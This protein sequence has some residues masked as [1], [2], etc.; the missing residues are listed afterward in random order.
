MGGGKNDGHMHRSSQLVSILCPFFLTGW[1]FAYLTGREVRKPPDY[2]SFLPPRAGITYR[3]PVFGSEI[4]RI[5]NA[6]LQPNAGDLGNLAFIINEYSTMSPF[7]G[8]N[9]RLLL[10]HQSYFALYDGSGNFIKDL[11]FEVNATSEPRW[12]RTDADV[13]YYVKGNQLKQYKTSTDSISLVRTFRE[14]SAIHGSGESDICFDG[15]HLVLVGDNK[16]IFVYEISSD[17]KGPVLN[18]EG[19][20]GF[21]Q[22]YITPNDNVL[23]GWYAVGKGRFQGIEL[24]DR[25]M[26]FLRQVAP[27]IGH[28]DVTRDIN[29][30]EVLIWAN[31]ADPAPICSNGVVKIN[32]S[33]GQQTCLLS[34]DWS[35]AFHVSAP[36]GNGWCVVTTYAPSDPDPISNWPLYTNEILQLKLDGSEVRRLAHHRSRP[37][38]GYNYTPRTSLSRDGSRL[39]YS[40]N[41]GLQSI[42]G[43]LTEYSDVYLMAVRLEENESGVAYNCV[44]Y[45]NDYP[46][47]SDGSAFLALEAGAYASFTFV[48][49]GV[50][51]LGYCDN[52]CG[53]AHVYVDGIYQASVDTFAHSPQIQFPLFSIRD[54]PPQAHRLVIQVAGTHSSQSGGAWVWID[55]FDVIFAD[56]GVSRFEQT[57]EAINYASCPW[58]RLESTLYSGGA[59]LLAMQPGALAAF[60]FRGT[61]ARWIGLRD[62]W[63]GTALVYVDGT[64]QA[65]IDTYSPVPETQ[66]EIYVVSGLHPGR[67]TLIIAVTGKKNPNSSNSWVWVDAFEPLP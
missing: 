45:R 24:Y 31:A 17:Q 9:S 44:W 32:L 12:S 38:N 53:I 50:T 46:G 2:F 36:D 5:T 54:L 40:S 10:M 39:V 65:E 59:A 63:S 33:D 13:F 57:S 34:L 11:P 37:F 61:G 4:K 27:T 26:N 18:R 58:Y 22:L 30:Q 49:S 16:E 35:L 29:G 6:L 52:W 55:A 14:Y 20:G 15:D 43:L 42:L 56:S 41:Y 7:N 48:G 3:D 66:A 64:L 1:A 21:D 62:E 51:W 19:L 47:H 60:T 28:M 67:H 23:V 8:D 25:N